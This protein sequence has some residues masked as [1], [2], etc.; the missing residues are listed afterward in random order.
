MICTM[1]Y[2]FSLLLIASIASS[3]A[4]YAVAADRPNILFI[5]VD[6]QS[7]FDL[8]VYNPDSSL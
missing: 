4:D 6:D 2:S 8:Q 3:F 5:I 7:P 1:R